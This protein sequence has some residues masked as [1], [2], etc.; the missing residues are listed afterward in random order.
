MNTI[1]LKNSRRSYKAKVR[2]QG[3]VYFVF[4]RCKIIIV[5]PMRK[6]NRFQ[7]YREVGEAKIVMAD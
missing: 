4:R 6:C 3:N 5:K 1:F 7:C 2:M